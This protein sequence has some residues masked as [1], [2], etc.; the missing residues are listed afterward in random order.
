MPGVEILANALTTMLHSRFY[1]ETPD[2]LAVLIAGLVAATV[3][4]G[5]QLAQGRYESLKQSV[6]LAGVAGLILLLSYL[7]FTRS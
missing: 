5:L 2:W 4:G 3:L 7:V 1:R 6:V